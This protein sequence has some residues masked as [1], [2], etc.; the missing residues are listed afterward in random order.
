[1]RNISTFS[2]GG[3]HPADR[4]ELTCTK[5][6]VRLPTPKHIII[7]FSQHLGVPAN[8]IVKKGDI[9]AAGD[10]IGEAA[11]FISADIH[12]PA[13]G[14]VSEIKE[15]FLPNGMYTKA[16][17]IAVD[18]TGSLELTE[19]RDW[20]TMDPLKMVAEVKDLGIVGMGGATFP[21]NVKFSV[22]KG[23]KAEYVVI[24]G[25]ECEPYLTSD[26]RIMLEKGLEVL[27]GALIIAK[28]VGAP[29]VY[30]GIENNKKDAM[31]HL[32]SLI[33]AHHMPVEIQP[34]RLKYPQGD[35]KQL[36][37][38]VI[39]KEVPSGALPIDI[40]AV[41]SNVGTA[42][43]LYQAIVYRKPLIERVVTVTGDAIRNPGNFLVTI[44]TPIQDLI[45]AC[46][47]FREQPEKMVAGG[48]MMGF[49]F[50]DLQTPV[51]KGTSGVLALT[52]KESR[53][54]VTTACISCG[55]CVA[56][57]P[58]GLQPT[59]LYKNIS[60]GNY[61]ESLGLGLL[62]CKECGC[63]AYVCPAKLPLVQGMR[64]GK[65]MSRKMKK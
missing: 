40:G 64:L 19:K 20:K 6:I 39:G 15:I 8:P 29:K 10:K 3:V 21:A 30:I 17:V 57:C 56:A 58:M 42:Q 37:K 55:R 61:T 22:P 11:G 27:E 47:G 36:L 50:Y 41:V 31:E 52:S 46:G 53:K 48:P 49:A 65:N 33:T 23:K 54:E 63:C 16:A 9:L 4:K 62:D 32:E 18:E 60:V 1:M 26:H 2:K 25:V 7:P 35:E 51:M 38:A 34:L 43:A 28:M 14:T 44:G 45:D 12:T 13:A 5:E 24:N 59:R